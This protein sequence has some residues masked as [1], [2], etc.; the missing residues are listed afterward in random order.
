MARSSFVSFHYQRDHWRVQQILNMGALDQQPE[1]PAQ[2]WEEVKRRGD[3][4]VEAWID[5]QMNYKKAVIV[6]IGNETASRKFVKYEISRAWSIKKPLLG[7]RIHGLKDSQQ[8]TDQPGA[9]PF[10]SFGFSDSTRTY[11]D[12]VPVYDPSDY[13]GKYAPNSSD[14]YAAIQTNI[15]T[16]AASGYKRP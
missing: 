16:W 8:S 11:A 7:I 2:N 9:N 4:A 15:A 6:L 3:A 13:T 12:Y 1:L 5:E 14:I 10:A